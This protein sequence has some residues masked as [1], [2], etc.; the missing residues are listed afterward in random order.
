MQ[1]KGHRVLKLVLMEIFIYVQ[2][3]N[4]INIRNSMYPPNVKS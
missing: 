3:W 4:T 1:Q 2:K